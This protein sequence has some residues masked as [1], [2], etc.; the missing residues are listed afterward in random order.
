MQQSRLPI[1]FFA[2]GALLSAC[3]SSGS[4]SSSASTVPASSMTIESPA[5]AIGAVIPVQYSCKGDNVS[6]PLRIAGVPRDAKSLAL[7][8]NDPDAPNGDFIHWVVYDIDPS[9]TE[10]REGAVPGG[11]AEGKNGRGTAQ[12]TGPC[13]PSGTHRYSF[14][15][16]ALDT[17]NPRQSVPTADDLRRDM[18]GHILA[19]AELM[20]RFGS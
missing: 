5:F 4:S 19:E 1:V 9:V 10:V 15:L 12:Y 3:A 2:A 6:P 17:V 8:V 18:Q 11:G 14:R 16:Y 7:I 13:P 20:G